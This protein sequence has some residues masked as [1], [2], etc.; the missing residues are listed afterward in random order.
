MNASTIEPPWTVMGDFNNASSPK[1]KK[2]LPIPFS[3]ITNFKK[4]CAHV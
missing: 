2:G 1:D 3:Y 4:L